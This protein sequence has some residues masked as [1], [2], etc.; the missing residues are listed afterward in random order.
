VSADFRA[1]A[2]P[3][4]WEAYKQG[5]GEAY[6]AGYIVGRIEA[7]REAEA[8]AYGAIRRAAEVARR[9]DTRANYHRET[10]RHYVQSGKFLQDDYLL[11]VETSANSVWHHTECAAS[12]RAAIRAAIESKKA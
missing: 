12:V 8:L 6:A 1:D 11:E 7:F 4:E 2:T 5:R 9:H 3:E 10:I